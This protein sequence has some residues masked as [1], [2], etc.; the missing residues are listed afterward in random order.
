MHSSHLARFVG[1]SE[2]REDQKEKARYAAR[3][4]RGKECFE[5][6]GENLVFTREQELELVDKPAR[7]R[8]SICQNQP[9]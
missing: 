8:I 6:S 5:V 2:N 7:F 4:H 3:D 9:K 1:V